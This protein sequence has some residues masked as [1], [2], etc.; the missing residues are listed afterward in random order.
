MHYGIVES[1]YYRDIAILKKYN[2]NTYKLSLCRC[3]PKKGYELNKKRITGVNNA[4][5]DNNISRAKSKVLEYALCN[6][7][8]Y[9]VTLT[10]DKTKFDRYKLKEYYKDFSKWLNNYNRLNNTK[11]KYILIPEQHKDGAWHM[12][13]LMSGIRDKHIYRFTLTDNI[14]RK[15]KDI[16]IAGDDVYSWTSYAKKYGYITM[17]KI[18]SVERVSRYI[19]KYINKDMAN[20]IKDL[21]AHMYYCSKGLNVATEIKRGALSHNN[22]PKF[23]FEND[24]VKI[25]WLKKAQINDLLIE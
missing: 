9:F 23:D 4:K 16:I 22:A 8:D 19:T 11:I 20:S 13:G 5:L 6:K 15:I 24:Y 25:K 10:I 17:T 14:P 1:P 21:G 18:K 2:D 12:H 3:I 7:F